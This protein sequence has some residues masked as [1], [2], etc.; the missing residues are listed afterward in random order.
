MVTRH[1]GPDVLAVEERDDPSPGPDEL[2]VRPVAS[3]VNF[4]EVYQ[5]EGVYP[6]RPPF[7]LGAEGAGEVVEVGADV[8]GV[9]DR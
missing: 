8:R 5:R 4:I 3:G 2:L 1:G 6:T 7:V 9:R